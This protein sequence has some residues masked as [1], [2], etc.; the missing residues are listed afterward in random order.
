MKKEN[1]NNKKIIIGVIIALFFIVILALAFANPNL[2]KKTTGNVSGVGETLE[3]GT[4]DYTEMCKYYN[5]ALSLNL[6]DYV[7]TS[8]LE[9]ALLNLDWDLKED[10]Q[11]KV[12]NETKALKDAIASLN[13]KGSVTTTNNKNSSAGDNINV[14]ATTSKKSNSSKK[15]TTT[16]KVETT[17]TKVEATTT[18]AK[19]N[20]STKVI[21]TTKNTTDKRNS[22]SKWW[23]VPIVAVTLGLL[24]FV[25]Y[26]NKKDK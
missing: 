6:Y 11:I 19:Q 24:G 10:D 20:I 4:A 16:T 22:K 12:D 3:V 26:K 25:A 5:E 13:K 15:T 23:V 7:D 9:D 2:L 1:K 14:T 17:I 8:A 18:V 21:D